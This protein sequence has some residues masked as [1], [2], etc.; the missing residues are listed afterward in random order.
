[1]RIR[2][3]YL[4]SSAQSSGPGYVLRDEFTTDAA[5]PLTSPRTCEPGPGNLT[6]IQ[7]DGQQ[8]IL[9]GK[10]VMPAQSSPVWGD[11]GWR[12]TNALTRATGLLILV[13]RTP[14]GTVGDAHHVGLLSSTTFP[15][16]YNASQIEATLYFSAVS[17][18]LYMINNPAGDIFLDGNSVWS[19]DNSYQVAIVC[20]GTGY[21][22][23]I[24]GGTYSDWTLIWLQPFDATANPYV[25]SSSLAQ[26]ATFDYVRVRQLSNSW[27]TDNGIALTAQST[28][29][30]GVSYTG[31][32]DAVIH[33]TVTAPNPLTGEGAILYRYQDASNYWKA[34]Y[35]SSNQVRLDSV[36]GGTATNRISVNGAIGAGQTRTLAISVRGTKH[37]LYTIDSVTP[38]WQQRGSEVNLSHLDTQTTVRP[39][40]TDFTL[41]TLLVFARKVSDQPAYADLDK[42]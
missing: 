26:A 23:F 40:A 9:N 2:R 35:N 15:T 5:A 30:S 16:S 19:T 27:T 21:F 42:S 32:A 8:S 11:Q 24:K 41:G 12:S 17:N 20:R 25:F 29:S 4:S 7:T 3:R 34:Y 36:S 1:M 6:L 39:Q 10:L 38:S 37:N 14:T 22:F 31:A 18:R 13:E 28:P 33:Q